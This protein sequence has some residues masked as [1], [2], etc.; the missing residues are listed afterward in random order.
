M[1]EPCSAGRAVAKSIKPMRGRDLNGFRHELASLRHIEAHFEE[2]HV[3]PELR[4][5]VLHLVA[6]HHGHSRPCFSERAYDRN[7][8]AKSETLALAAARRFASLQNQF[9]PWGLAYL[10]AI[11]KS[12]DGLA[13][14][15]RED[16]T[17]A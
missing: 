12:A 10:E 5:L 14:G 16:P 4:E 7:H 15:N 8:L 6:A 17:Y 1:R 2:Q 13:S 3:P 11:L 9:G